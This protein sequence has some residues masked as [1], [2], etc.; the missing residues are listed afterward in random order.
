[1]EITLAPPHIT[2]FQCFTT[3]KAA[4]AC[5][6]YLPECHLDSALDLVGALAIAFGIDQDELWL[7]VRDAVVVDDHE[8][9]TGVEGWLRAYA[10]SRKQYLHYVVNHRWPADGLFVWLAVRVMHQHL[11]LLHVS[12]IWTSRKSEQK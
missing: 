8:I 4:S 6:M 7:R 11:N 12:G 9:Q 3:D 5:K 1:M 2:A 10:I